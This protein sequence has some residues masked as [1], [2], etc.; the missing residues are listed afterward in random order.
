MATAATAADSVGSTSPKAV[1]VARQLCLL[2]AN[3]QH[4][5]YRSYD[6]TALVTS[7]DIDPAVQQDPT[8]TRNTLLDR[9]SEHIALSAFIRARF[10]G[11]CF[12]RLACRD[13]KKVAEVSSKSHAFLALDLTACSTL[14]QAL[15]KYGAA[16]EIGH[17]CERCTC[18]VGLTHIRSPQN[19]PKATLS[20]CRV[21]RAVHRLHAS[22]SGI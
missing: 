22:S 1:M 10:G 9:L 14:E 11:T 7:L 6:P 16:E 17:R 8:E 3:L 4:S 18:A 13:C 2:F 12:Y 21:A 20:F 19:P 5:A 15:R